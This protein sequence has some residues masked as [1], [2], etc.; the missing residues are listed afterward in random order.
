MASGDDSTLIK[1]AIFGIT[2]SIMCTVMVNVMLA[3]DSGGDYDF[4]SIQSYRE[5]VSRFTGESMLSDT[6]WVLTRVCTPWI[7]EMEVN[8]HIDEDGWLYGTEY[9]SAEDYAYIGKA[10][11]IRLDED[12]KSNVPI[13]VSETTYPYSYVDGL[14]W[15]ADTDTWYGWLSEN[16]FTPVGEFFGSDR[17]TYDSDVATVWNYTGYRYVFDPT[18]PFET[19][20][21]EDGE[22]STSVKDGALSLVWYNYNGQ[23]GLSGGLDVYGGDVLLA[24]YSATD[25][26][27]SYNSASGYATS[28]EFDFN[29]T[30]L[31]LSILFDEDA[32]SSGESL[33]QAW[34]AGNWSMSITSVSVG[35][36]LDIDGSNSYSTSIGS[37]LKTF[38]AIYTLDLPDIGNEWMSIILWLMVG[39]PM[40]LS[41]ALIVIRVT[42]AVKP[43]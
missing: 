20:A 4:D 23:E 10:A 14:K 6:P 39:L 5:E 38:I 31:T 13:S 22:Y 21:D 19:S 35:N 33:M 42:E 26:I 24:S 9:T 15:W 12:Y 27:N 11:F 28:Y 32:I 8:G 37:L 16:V 41:L 1:I 25:I 18:L 36:F 30:I 40:T 43:L 2:M 3:Q 7:P 29:G 34:T 17:Y